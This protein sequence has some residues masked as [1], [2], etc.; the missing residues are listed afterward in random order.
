VRSSFATRLLGLFAALALAS[1]G[2]GSDNTTDSGLSAAEE[3]RTATAKVIAADDPKVFRKQLI[4]EHLVDLVYEGNACNCLES[5]DSV[6]EEP[7]RR[8]SS[9]SSSIPGRNAAPRSGCGSTVAARTAAPHLDGLKLAEKCPEALADYGAVTF[10][11]ALVGSKF[12]PVFNKCFRQ[13]LFFFFELTELAPALLVPKPDEF[14]LAELEGT[15]TG[16]KQNCLEQTS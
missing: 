15:A 4:S 3:V 2:D 9:P 8:T 5:D 11:K 7:G 13:E 6:P 12:S 1:C 10:S 16:T 14:A